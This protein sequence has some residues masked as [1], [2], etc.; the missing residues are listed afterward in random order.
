MLTNFQHNQENNI[1][2]KKVKGTKI[3]FYFFSFFPY[4]VFCG[5]FLFAWFWFLLF[6]GFYIS[7]FDQSLPLEHPSRI[8]GKLRKK[9]TALSKVTDLRHLSLSG[10]LP[11]T[12]PGV[13]RSWRSLAEKQQQCLCNIL[14]RMEQW[15]QA[16]NRGSGGDAAG[17]CCKA[18]LLHERWCRT[19]VSGPASLGTDR[20]GRFGE[21]ICCSRTVFPHLYTWK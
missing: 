16:S 8:K 21:I 19:L 3:F 2:Q 13:S 9:P 17:E 6:F 15:L 11:G 7:N 18:Q 14:F 12:S 5:V 4:V 1:R 20:G 10:K